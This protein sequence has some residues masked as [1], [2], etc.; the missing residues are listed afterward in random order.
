MAYKVLYRK[1][2]PKSFSEVVGQ[3]RIIKVL[4]NSI[5]EDKV[6]HAYI[7]SGPRGT[8]KTS[9]AKI[10]AKSINCLDNQKGEPCNKCNFCI[11]SEESSDIIEIDA[12]S[13][14]GID[15][16]REI[17]NNV[18]VS[19]GS[20]FKVYIV[21]EVHM[22]S[23]NAFNALLKTL[24]EPPSN[25]VFIL[26]TT[27]IQKVPLTVL[28]RCQRLDFK[29]I[30][31]S[32][33]VFKLKEISEREKISISEEALNLIAEISDG[34]LRD[35]LGILEQLISNTKGNI[36]ESEV[37]ALFGTISFS[38]LD[39]LIEFLENNEGK[40]IISFIQKYKQNGLD[41]N[42][43]TDKLILRLSE[44]AKKIK[45]GVLKSNFSFQKIRTLINE[46]IAINNIRSDKNTYI[47]LE[48]VLLSYI[49]ESSK[50]D[51]I[52]SREI[53][54]DGKNQKNSQKE[55]KNI[56]REIFLEE[57][58]IKQDEKSVEIIS[59]EIISDTDNI[60]SIRINNCFCKAK[61]EYLEKIK[62]N[63]ENFIDII[64]SNNKKIANILLDANV[65]VSS[66]E[67][68]VLS[69]NTESQVK[70]LNEDIDEIEKSFENVFGKY[71]IVV[72]TN[73]EWKQE[74]DNYKINKSKRIEYKYIEEPKTNKIKKKKNLTADMAYEL[75]DEQKIEIN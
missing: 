32:S 69:V 26:A 33:I 70:L 9:V 60:K 23:T 10:F 20:K 37:N 71:K 74:A 42:N 40:E 47:E 18:R 24:E 51:K 38:E 19:G 66:D 3:D 64:K 34:A 61:K 22:L 63:W 50:N 41:A 2:R 54:L 1:H 6:S 49:E 68:V 65:C 25:V 30:D 67:H 43:F 62:T 48:L 59:R 17:R 58:E 21:D 31:N 4:V 39:M 56:S 52:I 72:I 75:F 29:K 27:D 45:L 11:S 46:L 7:F 5:S 12:A 14:N 8:G 53:I 44:L 16:I 28:S 13:N 73:E 35:A 36:G 55:Q 57:Q 15:E